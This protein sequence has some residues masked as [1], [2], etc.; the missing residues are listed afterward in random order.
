MRFITFLSLTGAAVLLFL[1]LAGCSGGGYRTITEGYGSI[2]PYDI[3]LANGAYADTMHF[4]ALQEGW[5]CIDM[6]SDEV[7]SLVITW[8]GSAADFTDETFIGMDDDGGDQE[9]DARLVFPSYRGYS[10]SC[11]FTTFGPDDFGTY[12]YRI[13][14]VRSPYRSTAKAPAT[15]KLPLA[16]SSY[17]TLEP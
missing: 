16:L 7:D 9:F 3:P 4:T 12:S 15:A 13:H 10:Y 17:R 11:K 5:I 6:M 14:H 2:T 1:G 8:W